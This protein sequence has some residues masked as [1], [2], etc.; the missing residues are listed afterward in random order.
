MP[1]SRISSSTPRSSPTVAPTQV[2]WAIASSPSS[3]LIRLTIVIVRSRVEPPAPYVTD[4]NA[5]SS[6][7]SSDA[8]RQRLS[9]PSSDFGGKN[10]NEKTGRRSSRISSIRILKGYAAAPS[11]LLGGRDDV[12]VD[13]EPL[14]PALPVLDVDRVVLAVGAP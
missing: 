9:M 10:S 8:A 14:L 3:C 2:K 6:C 5:G 4:T 1:A 13:R 11:F 12:E 7:F